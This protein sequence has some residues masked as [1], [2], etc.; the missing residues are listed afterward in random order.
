MIPEE[1]KLNILD[2][3]SAGIPVVEYPYKELAKQFNLQESELLGF[4][5]DAITDGKIKRMGMVLNH[6]KLGFVANAMVVWDV[7]DC[8]VDKVGNI[9]GKQKCVTLCYQR[10]RQLPEWRY[11]LFTMIHG[12]KRQ[13]VLAHLSQIIDNNALHEYPRDVLF[14]VRKFKQGGARYVNE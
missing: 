1:K 13:E 4:I 12:K 5:Q 14:S 10:P 9:L 8:V 7:P 11:N 6:H 2:V 3:L